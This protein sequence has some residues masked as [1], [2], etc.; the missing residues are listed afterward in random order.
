VD[1][2]NNALLNK[3]K[4]LLR[5]YSEIDFNISKMVILLANNVKDLGLHSSQ[6]RVY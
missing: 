5:K 3:A 1:T 6:T 4:S 2:V